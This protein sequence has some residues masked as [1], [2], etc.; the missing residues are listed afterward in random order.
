MKII[1]KSD[2]KEMFYGNLIWKILSNG[3]NIPVLLLKN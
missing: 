2:V 3:H 1:L